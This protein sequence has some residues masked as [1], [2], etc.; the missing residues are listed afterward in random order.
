MEKTQATPEKARIR[1]Y[2]KMPGAALWRSKT[3]AFHLEKIHLQFVAYDKSRPAGQRYTNNIHIYIGVPEFLALTQEA[4][5]GACICGC[6][7]ISRKKS[8]SRYMNIWAAPRPNNW[9]ST[10]NLGQTGR[11]CPGS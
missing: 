3:T 11:A 2:G 5:N 6:S 7:N 8:R 1:S 10:A 4:A 9:P